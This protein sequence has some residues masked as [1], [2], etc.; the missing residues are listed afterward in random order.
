MLLTFEKSQKDPSKLIAFL[1]GSTRRFGDVSIPAF[2]DRKSSIVEGEQEVMINNVLLYKTEE[3]RWDFKRRP[4][5]FI[6][7]NPTIET[8]KVFFNGFECSGTMCT[9]TA[10]AFD[11]VEGRSYDELYQEYFKT[12]NHSAL[13]YK[14]H[15]TIT[16]GLLHS[17]LRVAEN[18]NVRF[19]GSDRQPRIP[20]IGWIEENPNNGYMRLAGVNSLQE[21]YF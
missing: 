17:F 14:Y 15:G 16:P 6:V 12:R 3:G 20:G 18:V 11:Y 21:L 1:K 5:C 10:S 13:P 4:K 9:T 8:T 7:R 19:D 2:P